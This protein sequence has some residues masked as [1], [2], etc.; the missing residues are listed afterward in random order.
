MQSEDD[1]DLTRF[2][3]YLIG[4]IGRY[5]NDVIGVELDAEGVTIPMWRV[6]GTLWRHK[7]CSM[8]ELSDASAVALTALSRL[9][10]KMERDGIVGRKRSPKDARVVMVT[11]TPRGRAIAK[12]LIPPS[13]AME[14]RVFSHLSAAETRALRTSLTSVHD[15]LREDL[16]TSS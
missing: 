6:I 2:L 3:P 8:G 7:T 12:R 15:A 13:L 11:L 14:K 5:L 4:R 1:F 9:V 10:G 16:K